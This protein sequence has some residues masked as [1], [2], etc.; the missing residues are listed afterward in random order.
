MPG[1]TMGEHASW[2]NIEEIKQRLLEPAAQGIGEQL[3]RQAELIIEKDKI[4][5]GPIHP[6]M[7]REAVDSDVYIADLSGANPNVY[8]ELGVRWVLRDGVTILISQD[9]DDDVKFNVS[10]NRVIR[11]G[12]M[13]T[14][15]DR[16]INQ[17]VASAVRGI[18]EPDQV[19]SPVRNNLSLV[20]VPW[21]EWNALQGEI[22]RL[23]EA[24]ADDLVDAARKAAPA[25]AIDLLRQ[26]VQR[27]P[28]SVQA[29]YQLGISLREA[30]EYQDA[31]RELEKVVEL[32]DDWADGWRELGVALSKSGQ[33]TDAAKAFR[34]AV[35]L[36]GSDAETWAALGGL[37]R[38]MAR[39]AGDSAFDWEML[40]ES[41]DSYHRAS[42]LLG[43]DTYSLVNEARVDLLLSAV[44][45]P[46]RPPV[47]NRL[48]KLENLARFEAYPEPPL[49]RDPWKGFDLADTLLLT[50]GVEEGLAELRAAIKLIDPLDRES[51]LSSVI[52]PLR[53]FLAVDVL[54]E[55]TTEG[56]RTAIA[57]CEDAINADR[58]TS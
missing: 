8:L 5:S 57:V 47:I 2:K 29:H 10:G 16:A 50:G 7:F 30:A 58:P 33:L 31:I 4:T 38:R 35:E 56:V 1:S 44:K 15:L 36:D 49:R 27:N 23:K 32:K 41:R 39:S 12:P 20:V 3:G 6:S 21:T 51:V 14:E 34:S 9:I 13:P 11:Y 42:Q 26:A 53:D 46:N 18:Q 43:N 52:E 55:P 24:Q 22:A 28:V 40:R 45:P 48:R 54:D 17:I 19:D 37:H 25:Q